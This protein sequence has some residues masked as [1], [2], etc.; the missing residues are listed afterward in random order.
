MKGISH[1]AIGTATGIG[2]GLYTEA[3]PLTLGVFA[4]VGGISSLIPDLDTNGLAS[5]KITLSKGII[6]APMRLIGVGLVLYAL[7]QAFSSLLFDL[8][9]IIWILIGGGMVGASNIMKQKHMLTFTGIGVVIAGLAFNITMWLIL[10]GV[11]VIVAS[12]LP[13]RSYT[14]SLIGLG[15]FAIIL[16][17][18]E[19][20]LSFEGIFLVGLVGYISHLLAD[21]KL[22]PANKR[23]VK[24]FAPIWNKEF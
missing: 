3:S 9:F 17:M 22:L 12:F 16:Y 24:L 14:H 15:F 1:L 13:H 11:Y 18:A 10:L 2:I 6:K 21:M 23:G 8:S 4:I 5:N 19:E 20:A 7:Y